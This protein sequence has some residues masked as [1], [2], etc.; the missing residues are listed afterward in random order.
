MKKVTRDPV[1]GRFVSEAGNKIMK[2]KE[3]KPKAKAELDVTL[4]ESKS[5][6]KSKVE[7]YEKDY[8]DPIVQ[9]LEA[10][11]GITGSMIKVTENV[12][13]GKKAFH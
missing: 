13:L 5:K 3:A 7:K 6:T 2:I 9:I 8:I 10:N 4:T 11:Y 1:T 12:K